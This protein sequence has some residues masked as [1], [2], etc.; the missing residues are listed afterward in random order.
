[1]LRTRSDADS[2]FW[3]M[4]NFF[5][6]KNE[7]ANIDSLTL[8]TAPEEGLTLQAQGVYLAYNGQVHYEKKI[9]YV[10]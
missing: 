8:L 9:W 5:S 6:I 7:R 4:F 3:N 10:I 2:V 1:M